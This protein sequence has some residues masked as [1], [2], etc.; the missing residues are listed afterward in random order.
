MAY[1]P[2]DTGAEAVCRAFGERADAEVAEQRKNHTGNTGA[3]IVDEH[4]KAGGDFILQ[5]FVA[6]FDTKTAERPGNHRAQKH[7]D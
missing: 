5:K 7:R 6:L 2:A 1:Q 3:K 4:L